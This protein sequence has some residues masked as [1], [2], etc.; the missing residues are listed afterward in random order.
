MKTHKSIRGTLFEDPLACA[1][2]NQTNR[3]EFENIYNF[4]YNNYPD[5]LDEWRKVRKFSD[6][7]GYKASQIGKIVRELTDLSVIH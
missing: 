4:L 5:A 7:Y 1:L 6:S 2:D 3:K